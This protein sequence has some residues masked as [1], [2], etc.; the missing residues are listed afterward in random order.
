MPLHGIARCCFSAENGN[1][2]HQDMMLVAKR[3]KLAG[4][5]VLP[6]D[7]SATK[8]SPECE[9]AKSRLPVQA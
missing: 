6:M 3:D 4:D 7:S 9:K 2:Q 8:F 5:A 1:E